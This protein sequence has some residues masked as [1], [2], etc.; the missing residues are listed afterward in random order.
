[1]YVVKQGF[2]TCAANDD[3]VGLDIPHCVPLHTSVHRCLK[4][5]TMWD[6]GGQCELP[7]LQILL[8]AQL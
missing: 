4:R 3:H 8:G 6:I 7:L 2:G 1:M 5:D